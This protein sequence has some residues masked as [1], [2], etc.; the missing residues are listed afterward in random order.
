MYFTLR[1]LQSGC[2]KWKLNHKEMPASCCYTNKPDRLSC[3]CISSSR[4]KPLRKQNLLSHSLFK[5]YR[6]ILFFSL[7]PKMGM[8]TAA[9]PTSLVFSFWNKQRRNP[10]VSQTWCIAELLR[11][12][13][14]PSLMTM[15]GLKWILSEHLPDIPLLGSWTFSP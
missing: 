7:H 14:W 3:L 11:L 1:I 8:G 5:T 10:Q 15:G 2:M 4:W 12:V 13:N 9:V 6:L